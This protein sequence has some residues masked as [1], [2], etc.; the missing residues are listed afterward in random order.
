VRVPRA[1][2]ERW[3]A[4]ARA[5]EELT[6]SLQRPP[7]VSEI[8]GVLG[9]DEED[10]LEALEAGRS[11]TIES[12]DR[13]IGAE[14]GA[15]VVGDRV[16]SPDPGFALS[17]RFAELAEPMAELDDRD[18]HILFLRFFE[19]RTQSEIG[20]EVGVSQMHVSRLLRSALDR[21][22]EHVGAAEGRR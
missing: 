15:A 16:G 10:V 22:R 7:T 3:L 13:P 17:D 12:L 2:Q 5:R 19:G 18:R 11:H 1:L 8:A 6:Q 4:C 14:A 20:R 21:L 9:T